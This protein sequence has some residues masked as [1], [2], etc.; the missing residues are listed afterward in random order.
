[1][2]EDDVLTWPLDIYAW[3]GRAEELLEFLSERLPMEV[4]QANKS[5]GIPSID[6]LISA[7]IVDK[8]K[9]PGNLASYLWGTEKTAKTISYLRGEVA[10]G[11]A[12]IELGEKCNQELRESETLQGIYNLMSYLKISGYPV[13]NVSLTD[14][15][16]NLENITYEWG[17]TSRIRLGGGI[18]KTPGYV[19][20]CITPQGDLMLENFL[21]KEEN[22]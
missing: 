1:M 19:G 3:V 18:L 10:R 5:Y 15:E 11:K 9:N 8:I 22:K 20:I 21:K 17:W 4:N 2:F 7:G 12:S 16:R 14:R 13:V 6:L